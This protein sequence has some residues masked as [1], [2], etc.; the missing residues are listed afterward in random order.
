MLAVF[1]EASALAD[2]V[3]IMDPTPLNAIDG[4][5]VYQHICQ[6][7]HMPDAQGAV[8]AGRYPP[9]AKD[10]SL[11]SRQYMALTILKGR[12]N[13]PAF[14]DK[15]AIGFAG[16][17]ATLSNAQIAAVVNYVRANF[18]NHYKDRITADEVAALD[19]SAH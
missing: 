7:C 6:G 5:Q 12:R 18:G 8:G 16:A 14:G 1:M 9:L 3:G 17:P 15:H 4:R 2:T 13:M 19:E 11:G 10:P